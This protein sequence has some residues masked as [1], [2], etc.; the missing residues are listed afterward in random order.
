MK[1]SVLTPTIR[2]EGLE[3]VKNCLKEQTFTDFEWLVEVGIGRHDLNKAYNKMLQ[4]AQGELIISLQDFIK[5]RPDYLQKWW[6]AYQENPDTFMTAPVGK[7]DNVD[8][9]G[10]I[11][12]DWRAYRMN[13][14]DYLRDCKWDCWEIDNGAAPLAALKD[15]GGFDEQLD[16]WWSSDNVSVGKRAHLLGY[17]FKCLFDNPG[18]AFDHDAHMKHP[19]RGNERPALIKLRM[20]EYDENPRLSYL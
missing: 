3:I 19:F 16:Q 14:I 17:R 10:D 4:R 9:T 15:V 1:V 8:Y 18:V 5:V 7:V 6:N 11:R 13:H 2:P 12:W 20:D